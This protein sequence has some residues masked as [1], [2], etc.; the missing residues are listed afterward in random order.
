[1]TTIREIRPYVYGLAMPNDVMPMYGY[2]PSMAAI[3]RVNRLVCS[4]R[5]A[6][7]WLNQVNRG[8]A[9]TDGGGGG[10]RI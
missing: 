10:Q 4:V 6:L 3:L 1:M 7:N 9:H 5:L 2:A 8:H